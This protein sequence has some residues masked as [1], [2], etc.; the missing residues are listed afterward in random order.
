MLLNGTT[1]LF[2]EKGRGD[3]ITT[4]TWHPDVSVCNTADRVPNKHI[5]VIC[6]RARVATL[7]LNELVLERRAKSREN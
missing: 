3:Q 7:R 6:T 1:R 5:R 4:T 2:R